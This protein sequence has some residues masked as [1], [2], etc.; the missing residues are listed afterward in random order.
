MS[1][2]DFCS[3]DCDC[4]ESLAYPAHTSWDEGPCYIC[5]E[6]VT[7]EQGWHKEDFDGAQRHWCADHQPVWSR[8]YGA[9][10]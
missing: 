10:S 2:N 3:D 7:P 4:G 8:A 1:C 5:G 9:S 6:H